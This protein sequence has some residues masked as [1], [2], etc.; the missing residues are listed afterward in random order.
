MPQKPAY[1]SI[2]PDIFDHIFS[3]DSNSLWFFVADALSFAIRLI[4]QEPFSL[5]LFSRKNSRDS[6]LI[7]F[8][9]TA[10]PTFLLTVI[11]NRVLCAGEGA[12]IAI[13]QLL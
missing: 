4:S 11:P 6:R 1:P 12:I 3:S 10:L 2:E 8:R 9:V 5:C 7:R 13:K